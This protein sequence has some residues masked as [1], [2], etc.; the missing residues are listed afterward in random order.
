MEFLPFTFYTAEIMTVFKVREEA[1]ELLLFVGLLP[2][3]IE[4]LWT[5]RDRQKLVLFGDVVIALQALAMASLC[6]YKHDCYGLI[7][8]AVSY[9]L[10]RI[11]SEDF[12]DRYDVPY[13][14]IS[15]YSF[16]FV[17]IFAMTVL[18]DT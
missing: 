16:S 4:S 8:L 9:A 17:E 10:A 12:C 14:D 11:I 2:L 5:I 7:S 13:I 15:Q 3:V 18:K 6:F 1:K